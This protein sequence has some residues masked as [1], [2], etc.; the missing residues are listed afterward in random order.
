MGTTTA[1]PNPFAGISLVPAQPLGASDKQNQASAPE[2]ETNKEEEEEKEG[3]VPQN[4]NDKDGREAKDVNEDAT[5]K[6]KLFETSGG[7][8]AL[9]TGTTQGFG[10]FGALATSGTATGGFGSLGKDYVFVN[11]SFS[12]DM[13]SMCGRRGLIKYIY[14]YYSC[15]QLLEHLHLHLDNSVPPLRSQ[16][17]LLPSS[18][19][20]VT[21]LVV[22][23]QRSLSALL[24]HLATLV[25]L[26][27]PIFP[28]R[29]RRRLEKRQKLRSSLE[30]AYFSNLIRSSN[31]ESVV[32]VK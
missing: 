2:A 29:H 30:V 31:G 12:A 23:L 1:A 19:L 7:F 26:L 6:P 5:P 22:Q 4:K 17:A 9:G 14:L 25:R 28:K 11:T 10:S 27:G 3:D 16:G 15:F 21:F 20:F 8:S 18:L 13:H 24:L 32:E